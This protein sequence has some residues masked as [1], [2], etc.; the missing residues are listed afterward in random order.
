MRRLSGRTIFSCANDALELGLRE[1]IWAM[2]ARN[3]DKWQG[4]VA[5]FLPRKR[6]RRLE[7]SDAPKLVVVVGVNR[8]A[9]R[10]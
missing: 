8:E 6:T 4:M 10:I 5:W 3:A 2:A 7:G 9:V 1:A